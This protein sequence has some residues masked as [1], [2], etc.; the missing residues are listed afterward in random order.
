MLCFVCPAA[1]HVCRFVA[2]LPAA[3][4]NWHSKWVGLARLSLRH[5]GSQ[6]VL[7]L[8]GTGVY[9]LYRSPLQSQTISGAAGSP[10][11]GQAGQG[12]SS[13]GQQRPGRSEQSGVASG[14]QQGW[15]QCCSLIQGW[16]IQTRCTGPIL[17]P[18]LF[19]FQGESQSREAFPGVSSGSRLAEGDVSTTLSLGNVG[20]G[21]LSS[22]WGL[23]TVCAGAVR[24]FHV[25]QVVVLL[26]SCKRYIGVSGCQS[27]FGEEGD[28]A[29]HHITCSWTSAE[30]G[31]GELHLHRPARGEPGGAVVVPQ[32][33]FLWLWWR[34]PHPRPLSQGGQRVLGT[35][36]LSRGA[37]K[38]SPVCGA[39]VAHGGPLMESFAGERP[40][41][42]SGITP[43][44]PVPPTAPARCTGPQQPPQHVWLWD[45][46]LGSCSSFQAL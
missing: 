11:Q 14:V 29:I 45:I 4:Q 34:S 38:V 7:L 37:A 22:A 25:T 23:D 40:R 31:Q 5:T 27:G 1:F 18:R 42:E 2:L 19:F 10:L 24:W 30:R 13:S 16:E 8:V 26:S 33:Q 43:Q 32:P 35:T 20:L 12:S 39:M 9:C 41:D 3:R 15:E 44:P 21:L 6:L 28:G 46:N 17:A 36:Y